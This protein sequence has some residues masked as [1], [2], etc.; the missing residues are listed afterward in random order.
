MSNIHCNIKKSFLNNDYIQ[1]VYFV[2][3]I[4]DNI[5]LSDIINQINFRQNK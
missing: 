2:Y 3:N 5:N 1:K 4:T